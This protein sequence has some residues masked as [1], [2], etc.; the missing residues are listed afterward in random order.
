MALVAARSCL[1]SG[2]AVRRASRAPAVADLP[3]LGSPAGAGHRARRSRRHTPAYCGGVRTSTSRHHHQEQHKH[4]AP[5]LAGSCRTHLGVRVIQRVVAITGAITGAGAR[6]G[7]GHRPPARG[8]GRGLDLLLRRLH[9]NNQHRSA[10]QGGSALASPA[11]EA[12]L[13]GEVANHVCARTYAHTQPPSVHPTAAFHSGCQQPRSCV[14][15]DTAGQAGAPGGARRP[16]VPPP[17]AA[18]PRGR[19]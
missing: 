16:A 6:A 11:V 5:C 18:A 3:A 2:H 4:V 15:A 8:R 12:W 13:G 14:A 7:Q 19:G 9:T 1:G 17:L 10:G